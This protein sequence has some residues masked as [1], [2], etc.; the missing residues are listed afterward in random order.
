MACRADVSVHGVTLDAMIDTGAGRTIISNKIHEK[1]KKLLGVMEVTQLSLH[2]ASGNRCNIHGEVQLNIALRGKNYT[3]KAVV[4]DIGHMELILGMDFLCRI[5]ASIDLK[6]KALLLPNQVVPIRSHKLPCP[7]P[8]RLHKKINVACNKEMAVSCECTGWPE[9]TPA[10]FESMIKFG[11]EMALVDGIVTPREGKFFVTV[12]N[13]S[14]L[15]EK[16]DS[17]LYIGSLTQV[18]TNHDG[19][20]ECLAVYES[21]MIGQDGTSFQSP[22]SPNTMANVWAMGDYTMIS[23]QNCVGVDSAP[24]TV[25]Q[26]FSN[27]NVATDRSGATR[28]SCDNSRIR[29]VKPNFTDVTRSGEGT[30]TCPEHLLCVLP[31]GG[32]TR[33]QRKQAMALVTEYQ[34][35]FVGPDG[36]VGTTNLVQHTID[37]GEAKPN[38]QPVRRFGFDRDIEDTE[39]DKLL[40]EGK[41]VPSRSPWASPMGLGK[42]RDGSTRLCCDYRRLDVATI[43]DACNLPRIQDA[44]ASLSGSTWFSTMD[45]ATGR[46]LISRGQKED[47]YLY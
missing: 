26:R 12:T 44:L 29:V 47:C 15:R 36:K 25:K 22:A 28:K 41:I 43:K 16:L 14:S 17:G 27:E 7:F 3:Q 39:L 32:L 19:G 1:F 46:W 34:D 9:N 10:L 38:R 20:E 13:R 30:G 45:C 2:S 18:D 4:A 31:D 33:G 24:L 23:E 6:N 35:T 11:R 21:I 8:V 37:T 40:T 42:K 5:G